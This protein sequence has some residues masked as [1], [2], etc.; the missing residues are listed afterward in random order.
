MPG[1][2]Y[3]VATPIGNLEDLSPRAKKALEVADAI[4]CEDTRRT[5][6]L[7][8]HLGIKKPVPS[9]ESFYEHNQEQKIP[10]AIDWLKQGKILAL[11][12]DSGTPS[13]SD[14]GAKLVLAC[15]HQG[16]KLVPIPG[17]SAITA[18]LSASGFSAD[19][20]LFFGFLPNKANQR[21]KILEKYKNFEDA[22]V[23]FEA[24][25]RLN[26][27]INDL[28]EVFGDR[29]LCLARELTKMFEEIKLFTLSQLKAELK[30]KKVLGEITIILKPLEKEIFPNINSAG[31]DKEIQKLLKTG[32]KTKEIAKALSQKFKIPK[33]II[34][35]KVLELSQKN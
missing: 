19:R 6:A 24:P 27:T 34:Y 10:K 3:I 17:P 13:I 15:H 31:L 33:K 29:E 30:D 32:K 2:L 7:L 8:N 5:R 22:I 25:H 16:F 21:K 12:T 11:T 28:L 35:Q 26:K 4:F 20:F 1:I 9:L 23:I 14:P 18:S